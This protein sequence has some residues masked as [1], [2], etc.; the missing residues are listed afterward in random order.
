MRYVVRFQRIPTKFSAREALIIE[1]EDPVGAVAVLRDHLL[2]RGDDPDGFV[3]GD[4]Y[5]FRRLAELRRDGAADTVVA[6][7]VRL[8]PDRDPQELWAR[9]VAYHTKA[10]EEE[11]SRYVE[12]YRP[13]PGRVLGRP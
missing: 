8:H 5:H 4:G 12:P 13:V 7:H 11:A 1:A 6:G 2:R 3:P 10:L 9:Q